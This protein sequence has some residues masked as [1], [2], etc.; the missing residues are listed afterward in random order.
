MI[1]KPMFQ[2]MFNEGVTLILIIRRNECTKL[3]FITDMMQHGKLHFILISGEERKL[4]MFGVRIPI[5][6]NIL[7]IY[8]IVM[9]ILFAQLTSTAYRKVEVQWAK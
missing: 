7:K 1:I 2:N 4:I 6:T 9:N 3:I 8:E 5:C